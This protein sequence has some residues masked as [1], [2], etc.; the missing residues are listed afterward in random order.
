MLHDIAHM[1]NPKNNI[2]ESI[3]KTDIDSQTENKLV[4]TQ[5]EGGHESG[6]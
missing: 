2:N 3:Y 5:G 6:V 4:V 1:K